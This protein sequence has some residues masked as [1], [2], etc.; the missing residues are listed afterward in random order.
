MQVADASSID[1]QIRE[2]IDADSH[3]RA[4]IP[5]R[6]EVVKSIR[7]VSE[8]DPKAVRTWRRLQL[9][10]IKG[11]VNSASDIQEVRN[12]S[13]HA[14]TK[15]ASGKLQTAALAFLLNTPDLGGGG[16]SGNS[17]TISR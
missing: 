9:E 11:V 12:N 14:P 5:L 7:I 8:S 3:P 4:E 17:N 10:R 15:G 6:P 2:E 1:G 13:T 16:G